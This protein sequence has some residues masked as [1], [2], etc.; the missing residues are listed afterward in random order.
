MIW[1]LRYE[2]KTFARPGEKILAMQSR[3]RVKGCNN[4]A[5]EE[6]GEKEEEG[7]GKNPIQ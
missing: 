2:I 7:T 1:H 4:V 3:C 5:C 6:E